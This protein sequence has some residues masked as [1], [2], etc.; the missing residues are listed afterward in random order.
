MYGE[1]SES[2]AFGQKLKM[3]FQFFQIRK[4]ILQTV[5]VEKV[6]EE[7]RVICLDPMFPSWVMV[8]KLSK[9]CIFC[10]FVLTSTRNLILLKQFTYVHLKCLVTH[11][12]KMVLFS[13]N[14]MSYCFRDFR[15]WSRRI[16]LNFWVIIFF[17][18]LIANISWT[19]AQTPISHT[20]FWKSFMKNFRYIYVNCF[21]R[22]RFL[23]EVSTK[24]CTFFD[25]LRTITQEK[26]METR[27]KMENGLIYFI[28]FFH[29]NCL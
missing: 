22:L 6:D 25:N 12:H 19:V 4:W 21:S 28:Y 1:L 24:K 15:V 14:T 17:D 10:N 3:K 18:I 9:K 13:E 26:N 5:R 27:W 8:L 16:L 7:T 23:G 2:V 11:I 20:I 29:S